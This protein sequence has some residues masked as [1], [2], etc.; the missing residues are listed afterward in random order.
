MLKEHWAVLPPGS[1]AVHVTP[2]VP[3]GKAE[4]DGETQATVRPQVLQLSVAMGVN[5]TF[6]EHE[7]SS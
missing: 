5:D 7:P 1:V 2:V 4:P 3:T 6:A